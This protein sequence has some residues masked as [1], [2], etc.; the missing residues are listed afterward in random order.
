MLDITSS[1]AADTVMSPGAGS[2]D[3]IPL[4][5]Q[6]HRDALRHTA[7]LL[8]GRHGVRLVDD[9]VERLSRGDGT[10]PAIAQLLD[11]I[12]HLLALE[13]VHIDGSVEAAAFAAV[14]L[15]DP[16]VEELCLLLDGLRSARAAM[17]AAATQGRSPR[18][19]TMRSQPFRRSRGTRHPRR[20]RASGKE[21]T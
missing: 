19:T 1:H 8:G 3:P 21:V 13:N 10:T 16:V 9:L 17:S 11:R 20:R 15:A 5:V 14:E 12:E 4:F 7:S 6:G 2:G 18:R